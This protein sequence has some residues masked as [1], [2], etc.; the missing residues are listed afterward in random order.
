M[1]EIWLLTCRLLLAFVVE[2]NTNIIIFPADQC[3]MKNR[4]RQRKTEK[5]RKKERKNKKNTHNN[6][7]R[8]S[9][10]RHLE[11]IGCS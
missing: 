4:E 1:N 9:L 10:L 5:E 8:F 3:Q 7:D 6:T 2:C 11:S